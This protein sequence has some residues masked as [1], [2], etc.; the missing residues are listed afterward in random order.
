VQ[1]QSAITTAPKVVPQRR[2]LL[3]ELWQRCSLRAQLLLVFV[4][5]NLIALL[6]GGSIAVLRVR[7]QTRVEVAASMRLAEALVGDA[8]ALAEQQLPTE[9]FLTRLPM[10]LR[11]IRHVRIAVTDAAGTPIGTLPPKGDAD[12]V[13]QSAPHWFVKLVATPIESRKFAVIVNSVKV[14]D[15]DIVGEPADEIS[16]FWQNAVTTAAT[17]VIINLAMIAS[18]YALFGRVLDPLTTLAARLSALK[19]QS[20]EVRM[21][22]PPA[23]ELAVIADRFNALASALQ[24]ARADNQRLNQR[25]ITAQ[26]DERRHTALELHDEVGPCLFA[27][28]ATASS[29]VRVATEL[30][31]Q[32]RMKVI[33]RLG[34]IVRTIDHLQAINR[35]MLERL[36]PMALGHVPVAELLA[37]LVSEYGRCHSQIAFSITAEGIQR[38]YGDAIDLTLYRCVQESLTN[39]VRHSQAQRVAVELKHVEAEKQL[40]LIISD[41]G[42]GINADK[43]VAGFGMRGMRERIE[44]LGGRYAIDSAPGT[45]TCVRV[46]LPLREAGHRVKFA[47]LNAA[48]A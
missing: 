24:T 1:S 6:V 37:Q 36:R 16:E 29:I 7:A 26:D 38:S 45:G 27:L 11:S 34:D 39:A 42:C 33:E 21:P 15:V 41:D 2:L 19:H 13:P 30:P 44:G 10:Q 23:R 8:V 35:S 17:V 47:D 12:S 28:K 32:V 31:E 3:S 20:Y 18:L 43:V 5:L 9:R 40:T 22:K 4:A 25:L 14:G 48:N 46:N